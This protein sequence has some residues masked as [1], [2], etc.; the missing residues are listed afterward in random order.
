MRLISRKMIFLCGLLILGTLATTWAQQGVVSIDKLG[1]LM[2]GTTVR[3][4]ENMRFVIRFNNN[5]GV[6]CDVANGF[7]LSSPDGATWDSTTIDTLGPFV[8]GEAT[9]FVPYFDIA[10]ALLRGSPDGMG[11]DTVGII[12]AGNQTKLTRQMPNGYNDTVLSITAWFNGKKTSAGKHV[13]IDTS[14]FQ[15]GGTWVWVGNDIVDYHPVMQGLTPSQPYS[16]GLAGSRLGSGYCFDLYAPNLVVSV[17]NLT[18]SALEGGANPAAQTF[19][20]A[21]TGDGIG[22]HLAFSVVK[23]ASW[24]LRTPA[25]G[26]TPRTVQIQTN[27]TALPAGVYTDTIQIVS[28]G[29]GNSPVKIPVTLT[30]IAPAPTIAVSKSALNYLGQVGGSNP[31]PQTFWVSNV[32]GGS[33]NWSLS[34]VQSWLSLVPGSG[35]DSGLVTASVD[36]FALGVGDYY[37]TIVVSDP[38][39]TNTPVKIPVKLTLG[40]NLPTIAVDSAVNHIIVKMTDPLIRQRKVLIRNGGIGTL[41]YSIGSWTSGIIGV[42]PTSGTAP[43]SVQVTFKLSGILQQVKT[44]TMWVISPEGGNSPYPVVFK[45]RFVDS[46]AVI[47]LLKDT[48]TLTTYVCGMGTS[49]PLPTDSFYVYNSGG[50]GPLNVNLSYSSERFTVD[51]TSAEAPTQIGVFAT[52]PSLP[53]GIYY[54]TILVWSVWAGNS[55]QR[56]IVKYIRTEGTQKEISLSRDSIVVARQEGSGEALLSIDVHNKYPGCM[57]WTSQEAIPWFA[58]TKAS[59]NIPGMFSGVID[60]GSMTLGQYKDSFFILATGAANSPKRVP[61]TLQVWRYHGDLNWDGK[62]DLSDLTRMVA[63]LTVGSPLPI[64]E[65]IV[66]DVN[67]SNFVDLTDLTYLVSYLGYNG[68][69][70]CGNP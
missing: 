61:L 58:P 45:T 18:F 27:T 70:P 15:P 67:C 35:I 21:S 28:S 38:A 6:K 30:I 34:H 16:N 62:I 32:G 12:A 51:P 36:I 7:K 68:P 26:T 22:D 11:E 69:S 25:T 64:P 14:F 20:V 56:V 65:Y 40:S 59:G 60:V 44:D 23:N 13:C 3:A 48:V 37:D 41:T 54:D 50:D 1:G 63:Y 5:T 49:N 53:A 55:P 42:S 17:P 19:E 43:E 47:T 24:L 29:A 39:A 46:A 31:A 4:G 9:R 66:G 2:S 8:N 57:A 52:Y 10:F 33:L